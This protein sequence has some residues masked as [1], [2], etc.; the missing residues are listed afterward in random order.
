LFRSALFLLAPS[1]LAGTS[2]EF[3]ETKVRPILAT[4]CYAC[5][6]TTSM[7]GLRM[8]SRAALLKG[9][10]TGPALVP[11]EPE[12]SLLIRAVRQTE[13]LKMP[14]GG[15][16]GKADIDTLV[17]WIRDG[18]VWPDTGPAVTK[19]KDF[20]TPERRNFWSFVPLTKPQVPTP[21]NGTWAKTDLD[22]FI[23]SRL[24]KEG[25]T[26]VKAASRRVWLR[27]ASLDL[28]GLPP[29]VEELQAFEKDLSPGAYAKVVDRLLASPQ[30]G[31]RWGRVWLD[32]ARY[33]EDDYRSLDPKQRG[34]N[35]YPF[36]YLFRDWVIKSFNDDLP[37]DQFI[38]A[39]LA[40]DQMDESVRA[41]MLPA[42]GFLGLGPWYYDNGAVEITHADERNDRVDAVSRGFLGLTAACSRCHDHKYDPISQKDYYA[43]AGVFG[44]AVYHEYPMVPKGVVDEYKKVDK[45]IENKQKL[46]SEFTRTESRQLAETLALQSSR[47]LQSVWRVTGEPKEEIA[48]V[49]N[50]GKLD[51]ELFD[52]WLKFAAKPPK[53]YP[54]FVAWQ[55]MI[56]RGGTAE[57]A[58]KLADEFQQLLLDVLFESKELKEENDI[59]KAK[60]LEGTKPKKKA[61]LP[62][63]F[64]TNDDF[65]PGCGLVL[66]S[67]PVEKAN[68]MVDV[69]ERD[70]ADG[71][72]P[73]QVFD[74]QTP[75][76]LSFR[77]W[78]LERQLSAERRAYIDGLRTDIETLRKAQSPQYPYVHGVED[79][80]KPVN[81]HV[82]LRGNPLMLGDEVPRGFLTVLGPA[83]TTE[84]GSGRMELADEIIR[85]PIT[86]RVIVNRIW[87]VHF[88]TGLVDTPSNFGVAGE[89][90]TNPELLDHL[91]QLFVANDRSI[92][93]LHR[94]IMLSATYQLGNE[95]SAPAF[96]KDPA[97]RLYWRY[98]RHRMDAEQIRDS[99]LQVSGAL[100]PKMGGPSVNLSG[101]TTRRTI[102][103][104]VSRYKLDEYL[105][106]FDFPSPGMS[107]EKRFTTSVPLQRLF[108]M[109]S[110]FVQQQAELL[111]RRVAVEPDQKAR[112]GKAYSLVFGRTPTPA[113]IE[114]GLIYLKAE[115]LKE[116]DER[117]EAKSKADKEPAAKPP[118]KAPEKPERSKS[119]DSGT[120]DSPPEEKKDLKPLP[121]TI[122]GRYAKILLSS[123]E[124][125]FVE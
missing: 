48:K 76:L 15:K 91:S 62:N 82:N 89:R 43:L 33:G 116:Y 100:D 92:K 25:L 112:I 96:E 30:Y 8:D 55:A 17:E 77:K 102:Y 64:V 90:P 106:L 70:L 44:N 45:Q 95:L 122:W 59:I 71:F 110:A 5:H 98:D 29:T 103:G 63:E 86:T 18:A 20:I 72:D 87:K 3:F 123:S 49:A 28:I 60:A 27:R 34:Y 81:L 83:K 79:A 94:E 85:Q 22:R 38:K 88:G 67:L 68:L 2:S 41:R 47:Y 9:G 23:L 61:N 58:K 69:F 104:K 74:D 7:G 97:N 16:L 109:N 101:T 125:L 40:A 31:E 13:A 21:R 10:A 117:R 1:L 73:A 51:Y 4:Q 14:K 26:P 119:S 99:L 84:K 114:A 46:M 54:Y 24:E 93:K 42:L 37:F 50:E 65:C 107:A 124:F 66:K 108:L 75:G 36:A 113:E 35:P 56:K 80:A 111:A 32:I 121:V 39:Q 115:P 53:F 12:K 118:E 19:E 11:G 78:G 105:Q 6:S 52:R 57:E 120:P